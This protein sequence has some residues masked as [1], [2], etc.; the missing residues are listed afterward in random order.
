MAARLADQPDDSSPV[1]SSGWLL[2]F[3]NFPFLWIL[4]YMS[5]DILLPQLNSESKYVLFRKQVGTV[6]VLLYLESLI[7]EN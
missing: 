1:R 4:Y 2:Q 5:I 6:D 3:L 7:A